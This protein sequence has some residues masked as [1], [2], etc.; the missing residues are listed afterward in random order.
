MCLGIP[1][2]VEEIR[3]QSG[4]VSLGNVRIEVNLSLLANGLA[5]GDYVLV[6]AGFAIVRFDER[7]ARETISL[8]KEMMG[9]EVR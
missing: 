7:E 1:A 3:G 2:R 5:I 6:H 9:D 4:T 8:I